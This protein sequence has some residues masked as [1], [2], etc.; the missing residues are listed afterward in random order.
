MK[1]KSLYILGIAAVLGTGCNKTFL[2]VNTNP[3][4]LPTATP[5][6]VIANALNTTATNM[7]NPN[8]LGSY[9]SGQ[10]TQSNGYII[11]TTI[12]AYNFTNGDFNYWD[13]FYDNLND[14]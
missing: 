13:G 5:A 8:E 2:D 4:S 9:W 11:S 1:L 10:W 14:Y 12:F 6:F 7:R 3:N